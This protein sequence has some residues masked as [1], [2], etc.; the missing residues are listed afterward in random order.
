MSFEFKD[1]TADIT[2]RATGNNLSEAFEQAA[3]GF[4]EII[5]DSSKVESKNEKKVEISS[6][7]LQ[8]LLFDWIDQLIFLFDT[9]LFIGKEVQIDELDSSD[10][11]KCSLKA[12]LKGEEFTIGKHPQETEVKAM[13][14][15]F[16]DIGEDYVEFTVD[17]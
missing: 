7:D 10:K 2:I 3:L 5:T 17:I 9:E 6:E 4:Y 1:H 12:T 13:T 15:S 14:Y 16:M 8:S 11:N